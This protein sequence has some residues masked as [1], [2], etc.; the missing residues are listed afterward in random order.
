MLKLLALHTI[1]RL[2]GQFPRVS[3]AIAGFCG[4]IAWRLDRTSRRRVIRNL[5]PL[6]NGNAEE[7][8]RA[9]L[10]VFQNVARYYVDI[11]SLPRRD[12]SDFERDHIVLTGEE[13]LAV[14]EEASPIVIVSAHTGNPEL[15]VQA[16]LARGR[17]FVA[18]VEPLRPR[19]FARRFLALRSSAG[20]AF[21]E[22]TFSGLRVCL[23]TLKAGGLLA[24]MGDRDL[25]H[26]GI[27]VE[28]S[29]RRIMLP[30]GPWDVAKRSEAVILPVFCSRGTKDDM[31][32]RIEEP[33][34]IACTEIP[35]D[36]IREAAQHW[37]RLFEAHLRRD[38]GQ[39]AVLEDFWL[40]HA[41][42]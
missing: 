24:M 42:G 40:A 16:L 5:L 3:Y 35:G 32:V 14:L 17:P 31:A 19:G 26:N 13:H 11:C 4:W 21:H 28:L 20:G 29:G 25:Q 23:E 41:C 10:T 7:A 15:A 18:L 27:C 39:W 34:R 8:R 12:L 36:D 37:A 30:Q 22:T 6:T 33:F 9:S 2:A 38:P 1:G